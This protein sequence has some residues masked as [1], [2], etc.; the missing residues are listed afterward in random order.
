MNQATFG[1]CIIIDDDPD[2]LLSA[3][4]LLRDLF[5]DVADFQSPEAAL[6]AMER[7]MQG[8]SLD[9]SDLDIE[10]NAQPV[11]G[12]SGQK[13]VAVTVQ[14]TWDQIPQGLRPMLLIRN[15][16]EHE[17]RGYAVMRAEWQDPGD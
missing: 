12:E 7:V 1:R 13:Y 6:A 8:A 5:R 14:T 4:L 10:I 16:A 2:I 11:F 9:A 3:R 17:L 15:P